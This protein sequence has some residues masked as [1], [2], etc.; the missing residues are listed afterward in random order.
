MQR[1]PK[2]R[3]EDAL[4]DESQWALS[5]H[6]KAECLRGKILGSL[7]DVLSSPTNQ[8]FFECVL[9]L[10]DLRMNGM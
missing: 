6:S 8:H 2:L 5:A 3:I 7:R 9:C 4:C 10:D 1:R